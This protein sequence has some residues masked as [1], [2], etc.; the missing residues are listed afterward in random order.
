MKL[1]FACP[2][3][4]RSVELEARVLAEDVIETPRPLCARHP[5][6]MNMRLIAPPAIADQESKVAQGW[7]SDR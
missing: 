6:P 4:R 5:F 2:E 3:C 7:V 1:V